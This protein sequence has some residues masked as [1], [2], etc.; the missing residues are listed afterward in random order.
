M[1]DHDDDPTS[2]VNPTA[3][4]IHA[5]LLPHGALL[6]LQAHGV[7]L[8][9]FPGNLVEGG[10]ANLW[11]RL[12]GDGG[13]VDVVALLGPRSPLSPRSPPSPTA[14]VSS[15]TPL[16]PAVAAPVVAWSSAGTWC[17]LPLQLQL[18]LATAE[19][20]WFWHLRVHNI[21]AAPV[22]IDLIS[23]QDIG[24]A[25][26][27]ALRLNEYYVS[28]YLDL[29]P[30]HHPQ[31]GAMVAARQNQPVAGRHPWLLMGSLGRAVSYATDALQLLGK[32]V[33]CG[34]LAPGLAQGLPG[35]RLQHEHALAALQEESCDLPAGGS[36]TLGVF[37]IAVADHPLATQTADLG[38]AD[39]AL[40]LPE[41]TPA[42]ATAL[43]PGREVQPSLFA[44]AS[45]LRTIDLS[46][47][48]I[49]TLF[50]P[51]RRHEER[52]AGGRLLSFFHADAAHVVLG[53]KEQ[54]V[55]RPHG[56][57]LRSGEHAVPDE[58]ALT[59]TVWM[60]GVFHSMVTQGHVAINRLL[61]TVR[62]ALGQFVS[63]GLR[64]FVDDGSG[65]QLLGVPSAFEMRPDACRWL[66]RHAGG[67]L[68]VSSGVKH[69]PHQLTLQLRVLSG[70]PLKL[71]VTQ[72]V[73]LGG[74]GGVAP[75]PPLSLRAEGSGL[76]VGVPAD[77]ELSS[78]FPADAT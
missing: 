26:L 46:A 25:P 70:P 1:P 74:D 45:W 28:H 3:S 30:L 48:E 36:T 44:R 21:G 71:L 69:R 16:A 37:G 33:R 65:W 20:A 77:C 42:W 78:R 68:V 62:G 61:S 18:R 43:T 40:A 29:T 67:L 49:E 50:G 8:N 41:A 6:R 32:T 27:D 57:L 59:S 73:V 76:F 12:H 31:R 23:A 24:L 2:L 9:M 4:A 39:R 52:D 47:E 63:M 58:T 13:R 54:V 7:M 15:A 34:G 17:G 64:V 22:R 55:T 38:H 11:L 19:A 60:A 56:H 75:A 51:Q 14:P 66:Y 35:Q 5:E 10:P 53:A 72:H